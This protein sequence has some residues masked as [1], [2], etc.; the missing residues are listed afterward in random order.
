MK[1][2]TWIRSFEAVCNKL[3]KEGVHTVLGHL[4]VTVA[5]TVWEGIY[6]DPQII[7]RSSERLLFLTSGYP[8]SE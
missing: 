7:L 1:I 5:R 2:W 3:E 4:D 8:E 6:D